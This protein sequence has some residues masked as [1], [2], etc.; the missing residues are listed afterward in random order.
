MF[1]IKASKQLI[2]HCNQQL[3]D[4]SFGIR[5][6]K[7]KNGSRE[8][9]FVGIVSE[10]IV[11]KGFGL[12][13][14]TC[15]ENFIKDY[16]ILWNGIKIDVK[17][18]GRNSYPTKSFVNNLMLDQIEYDC[19]YYIFCSYHKANN[20]ATICGFIDKDTLK[21]V[22]TL[23]PAGTTRTRFDGTQ[24]QLKYDNYEIENHKL[25]NAFSFQKLKL[26]LEFDYEMKK[27]N[28][29]GCPFY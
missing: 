17:T 21:K 27:G 1:T 7:F 14:V 29:Y 13:W 16:D 20:E 22:A 6:D 8:N 28:H 4:C 10:S 9:Q 24:F 23:L 26:L 5:I 12:P 3:D 19:E 18:V 15:E 2:D 25:T 11:R